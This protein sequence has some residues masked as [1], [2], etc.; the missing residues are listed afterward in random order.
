MDQLVIKGLRALGRHGA[1]TGE[2]DAPQ[3]FEVD[4][5]L[6]VDITHASETDALVDTVD[7]SLIAAAATRVVTDES[8]DL[9]ETLASRIAATSLADE[10]V[11]AVEVEVRKLEP[12]MASKVDFAAVRIRRER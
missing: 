5:T 6:E 2:K 10:R 3:P 8:H 7:Y 4:I 12:A 11:H 1:A 9:I